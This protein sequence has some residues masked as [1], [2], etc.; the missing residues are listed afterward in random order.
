MFSWSCKKSFFRSLDAIFGKVGRNTSEEVTLVL[1]GLECFALT[2][3]DMKSLDFAVNKSSMKL[4]RSNN[5]EI[6]AECRR[7]FHSQVN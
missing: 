2:K 7:Y 1:Y 4:F 6:I 5:T 3:S